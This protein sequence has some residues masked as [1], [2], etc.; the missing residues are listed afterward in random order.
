MDFIINDANLL[1][2][3]QSHPPPKNLPI[4]KVSS[5][6]QFILKNLLLRSDRVQIIFFYLQSISDL[7]Q[8]TSD[9][10]Q[11]ISDVIRT[12]SDLVLTTSNLVR[13]TWAL[14][15]NNMALI[16]EELT[17]FKGDARRIQMT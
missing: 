8:T 17:A 6:I 4:Y 7:I 14:L 16:P 11:T 3:P 5:Q 1:N 9:L 13:I 12:T 15:L 2:F 10:V